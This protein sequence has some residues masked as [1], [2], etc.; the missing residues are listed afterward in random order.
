MKTE[1]LQILNSD[2][3]YEELTDTMAK[4]G[5]IKKILEDIAIE[6]IVSDEIKKTDMIGRENIVKQFCASNGISTDEQFKNFLNSKGLTRKTFEDSLIKPIAIENYKKDRW[7]NENDG[8]Y[9]D[10]KEEFDEITF[11][12]IILANNN[13]AQEIYFRLNDKEKS[14]E[15]ICE[16]LGVS[17]E[18][19]NCG[20]LRRKNIDMKVRDII[21]SMDIGEISKPFAFNS[22]FAICEIINKKDGKPDEKT[23]EEIMNERFDMMIAI[24]VQK[25]LSQLTNRTEK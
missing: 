19:L 24:E 6:R 9:Y 18:Q 25:A 5:L 12:L 4:N 14:W 10:N 3:S 21:A 13:L 22:G 20:P 2:I 23:K 11:K 7:M 8:Y 16:W 17:P 1:L 15:E